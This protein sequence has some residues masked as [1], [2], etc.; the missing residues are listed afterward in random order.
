MATMLKKIFCKNALTKGSEFADNTVV[1]SKTM[2]N[3]LLQ[4]MPTN[5]RD[6]RYRKVRT[7]LFYCRTNPCRLSVCFCAAERR[8]SCL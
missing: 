7:A 2:T 5:G 1:E 8:L 3:R 4:K 6:L